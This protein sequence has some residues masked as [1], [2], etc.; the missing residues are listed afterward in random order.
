MDYNMLYQ[1]LPK[2]YIKWSVADMEKFLNFIGLSGLFPKFSKFYLIQ[3]NC[4]LMEAVL[5]PLHNKT[6]ETNSKLNPP[7]P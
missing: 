2:P 7:S 5:T 3:N 6:L 4:Q 1:T